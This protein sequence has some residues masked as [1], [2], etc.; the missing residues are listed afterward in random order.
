MQSFTYKEG[1]WL[2]MEHLSYAAPNALHFLFY[3]HSK[4]VFTI[5]NINRNV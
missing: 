1:K 2:I 3:I 4:Q 5:V